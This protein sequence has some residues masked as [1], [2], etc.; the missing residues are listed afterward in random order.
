[1]RRKAKQRISYGN[2]PS[3]TFPS[4]SRSVLILPVIPPPH[5]PPGHRL[6]VNSLAVDHD[7]S[8]L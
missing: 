5:S 8:I 7:K 2:V 4:A 6:G 1:M 3:R